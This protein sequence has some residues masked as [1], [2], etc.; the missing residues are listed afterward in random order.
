MAMTL[1]TSLIFCSSSS[2]LGVWLTI[3][4]DAIS[5]SSRGVTLLG[6]GVRMSKGVMQP[7]RFS[8]EGCAI[9]LLSRG[10]VRLCPSLGVRPRSPAS[11]VEGSLPRGDARAGPSSWMSLT[12]RDTVRCWEGRLPREGGGLRPKVGDT[13]GTLSPASPPSPGQ[14]S[15]VTSDTLAV[16][17]PAAGVGSF[18]LTG[19]ASSGDGDSLSAAEL[20]RGARPVRSTGC[21]S[22]S[23]AR[24]VYPM[25]SSSTMS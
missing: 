16:E 24:P 14:K 7:G 12:V 5:S 18:V 10:V 8:S 21:H 4:T 19:R 3:S 2:G 9:T 15:H 20:R 25:P 22:P 11:S 6:R 1:E 13:S 23:L 17:L